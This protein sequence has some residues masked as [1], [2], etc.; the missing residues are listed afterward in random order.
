MMMTSRKS[1]TRG[2]L[3]LPLKIALVSYPAT[4]WRVAMKVEMS[5]ARLSGIVHGRLQPTEREQRALAKIL[6]KPV[7]ELFPSA[8]AVIA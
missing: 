2:S 1:K 7:Q 8:P 5:Q 4:A 3:N 6:G